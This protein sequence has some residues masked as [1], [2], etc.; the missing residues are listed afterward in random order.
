M[1][2]ALRQSLCENCPT[3]NYQLKHGAAMS[4]RTQ[5]FSGQHT[6]ASVV[7]NVIDNCYGESAN[8]KLT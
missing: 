4:S 8:C 2:Q 6:L 7:Y 5:S 3:C 1:V